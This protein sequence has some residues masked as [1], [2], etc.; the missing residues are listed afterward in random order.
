MDGKLGDNG[1]L[2]LFEKLTQRV[3][4]PGYEAEQRGSGYGRGRIME[5]DPDQEARTPAATKRGHP[6]H[7]L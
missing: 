1:P 3:A 6:I 2:Q 5:S 4:L 7:C